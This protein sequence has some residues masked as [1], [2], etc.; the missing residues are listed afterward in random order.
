[1]PDRTTSWSTTVSTRVE[2][3]TTTGRDVSRRGISF[4]PTVRE[5]ARKANVRPLR[6]RSVGEGEGATLCVTPRQTCPDLMASGATCV[7]RLDG[8]RDSAIHTKYRISLRSSSM[9]EPRYPLPRVVLTFKRRL[10]PPPEHTANGAGRRR[11][12]RFDFPWR[13]PRRCSLDATT[14][15][16]ARRTRVGPTTRGI[17]HAATPMW[18][19]TC[20]RSALQVST[21]ILPQ[22]HL[23]K[24]CYDFSFL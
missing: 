11:T 21:M 12:L 6:F 14:H 13:V 20:S 23:R 10:V 16:G 2:F 9:R 5:G 1:M 24:P 15:A 22:V 7:Q 19:N 3:S 4:G 17:P 8:S 18:L